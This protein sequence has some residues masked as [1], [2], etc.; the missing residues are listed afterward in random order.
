MAYD[1][2]D[3]DDQLHAAMMYGIAESPEGRRRA[4]VE[5][6]HSAAQRVVRHLR[7]NAPWP[8]AECGRKRPA[9]PLRLLETT[10]EGGVPIVGRG[11]ILHGCSACNARDAL[12]GLHEALDAF[13]SKP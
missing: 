4:S 1:G 2:P 7:S 10:L 6:L 9:D 8:C 11:P 13:T 12:D 3:L 5:R